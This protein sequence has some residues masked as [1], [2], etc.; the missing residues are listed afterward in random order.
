[1]EGCHGFLLEQQ[2]IEGRLEQV[3]NGKKPCKHAGNIRCGDQPPPFLMRTNEAD[4]PKCRFRTSSEKECVNA[5]KP[6]PHTVASPISGF[7]FTSTGTKFSR[8]CGD[9]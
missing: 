6:R 9:F 7:R 2:P 4:N 8:P 3:I 1:M 5:L